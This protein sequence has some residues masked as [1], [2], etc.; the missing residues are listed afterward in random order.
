MNQERFFP[1]RPHP[2]HGLEVG[3]EPPS[4]VHAFVEITPLDAVK[5]EI[6]KQSGYLRVDRPQRT[7]SL[8]PTLYGFVPRTFCGPGVSS[9]A[10]C[11]A[12][13]DHDPLDICVL[14]ERPILRAEVLLVVRVVGG[15]LMI[16]DGRADDKIV[17]VLV[18]DPV[19][20]EVKDLEQLPGALVARLRHYFATYKSLPDELRTV[21]IERV[22][23]HEH[24]WKVV[25]AA[26]QDYREH[27]ASS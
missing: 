4:V 22:Y 27:F 13:G 2:W 5:Y 6:D 9:L 18:G 25:E 19:W 16:D 1:W 20:N 24:A 15:L 3:P 23:G 10:D 26:M 17:A 12:D 14:T 21:G 8:P 11:A 7:S